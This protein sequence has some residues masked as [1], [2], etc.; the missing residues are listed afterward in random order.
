MAKVRGPLM[1]LAAS[2]RVSGVVFNASGHSPFAHGRSCPSRSSGVPFVKRARQVSDI[3]KNWRARTAAQKLAW[4]GAASQGRTGYQQF[5]LVNSGRYASGSGQVNLVGA[6][7]VYPATKTLRCRWNPGANPTFTVAQTTGA[8][9][10]GFLIVRYTPLGLRRTSYGK[11]AKTY[12]ATWTTGLESA[13]SGPI[14]PAR[15]VFLEASLQPDRGA[16]NH[17]VARC[18]L[19]NDGTVFQLSGTQV[20]KHWVAW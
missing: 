2:G 4:A 14:P 10:N 18:I 19:W 12:L 1:S 9:S 11:R 7:A 6:A 15:A 20:L 16:G 13:T 3:A 17:Y 5:L 8:I